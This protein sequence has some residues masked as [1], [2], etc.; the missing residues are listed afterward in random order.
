MVRF[1]KSDHSVWRLLRTSPNFYLGLC[2]LTLGLV[3][4][5]CSRLW[6]LL[7]VMLCLVICRSL[8]HWPY[9]TLAAP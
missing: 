1:G 9:L 5:Y 6:A 2:L 4:L 8:A 3:L 7:R